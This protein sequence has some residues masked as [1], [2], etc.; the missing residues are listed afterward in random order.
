MKP[1]KNAYL[2]LAAEGD[3]DGE[4]ALHAAGQGRRHGAA[5]VL[6]LQRF[7]HAIRFGAHQV[8]RVAL[9]FA[10]K[11]QVLLH[12]QLVEE[13][14]VLRAQAQAAADSCGRRNPPSVKRNSTP[15]IGYFHH[16]PDRLPFQTATIDF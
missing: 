12:G 11:V 9:E 3:A 2:G 1:E 10:E 13:H 6:E 7:D 14:V 4:L 8:R 5:F 16:R 15:R